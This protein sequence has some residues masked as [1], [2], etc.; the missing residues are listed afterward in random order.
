MEKFLEPLYTSDPLAIVDVLPALMNSVK[1]V[2]SIAR[3]VLCLSP[4]LVRC[5]V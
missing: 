3:W 2:Y 1:M 4:Q 5:S